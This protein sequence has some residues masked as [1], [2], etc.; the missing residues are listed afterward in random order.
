MINY[1]GKDYLQ[2]CID[3]ILKNNHKNYEIIIVDNN[4]IDG[5]VD[6]VRKNY[7][8][9]QIIELDKNYGYAKPNNIGA[10]FAKGNVLFFLNNDT[11]I[12]ENTVEEILKGFQNPE[13]GICQSLLLHPDNS[14]DSSGDYVN[15]SGIP[16]SSKNTPLEIKPILSA[17]GAGMMVKRE[18]FWELLGFD[19]MFFVSFEDVDIGWR[20][21]LWGYK[22]M[23]VPTSI[24]IHEGGVTVKKLSEEIKF[25][26]VKNFLIINLVYFEHSLIS[27]LI[28]LQITF[29][30][31]KLS[32]NL[33]T[34]NDNL[35][36]LPNFST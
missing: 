17:R 12:Y 8:K 20:S 33:K 1:N 15:Y 18:I 4:S 35:L 25:H 6:F 30:T 32:K 19:E 28:K 21:W 26:G 22:V 10:K 34:N 9:I 11:I 3:S 7:S 5:S 36:S 29:L 23:L 13:I 14:V 2:K 27:S 24:I 31:K 16:F